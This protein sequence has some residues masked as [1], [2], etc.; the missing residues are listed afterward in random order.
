MSTFEII[1]TVILIGCFMLG[2]IVC[3]IDSFKMDSWYEK[4]AERF[5][6]TGCIALSAFF[7]LAL[8]K[9]MMK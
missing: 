1:A 8:I 5:T 3:W 9:I 7:L 4:I 2:G 6:G